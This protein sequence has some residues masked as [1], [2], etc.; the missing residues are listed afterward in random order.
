MNDNIYNV[1]ILR[2]HDLT[3][4]TYIFENDVSYTSLL[5]PVRQEVLQVALI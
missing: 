1:I 2:S 5:R 4:G 3:A